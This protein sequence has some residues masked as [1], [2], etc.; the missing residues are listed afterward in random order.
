MASKYDRV[1]QYGDSD[2][3]RVLTPDASSEGYRVLMLLLFVV[4]V[5]SLV[6]AMALFFPPIAV[7]VGVGLV[8]YGFGQ[9]TEGAWIRDTPEEPVRS[10]SA[11][12]SA[13]SGT[14]VTADEGGMTAPFT[15]EECVVARWDVTAGTGDDRTLA[16][17]TESVPFFVDDGTGRLLVRPDPGETHF[18]FGRGDFTD[19]TPGIAYL[20]GAMAGGAEQVIVEP[21][22]PLP[23][24]VAAFLDEREIASPRGKLEVTQRLLRPGED[25]YVFGP[26]GV[27][28]GEGVAANDGNLVAAPSASPVD[29]SAPEFLVSTVSPRKLAA[30]RWWFRLPVA[31]GCCFVLFGGIWTILIVWLLL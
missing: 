8:K 14:V 5:G 31:L 11:G 4:I 26:V 16:Q 18:F 17:S 27:R 28:D 6:F 3:V 23:A 25:V 30:R 7:L 29:E 15:D 20:L 19:D 13:V 1:R 21:G 10:V 9:R 2:G 24:R 22:A 12:T